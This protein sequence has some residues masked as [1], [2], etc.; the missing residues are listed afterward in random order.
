MKFVFGNISHWARKNLELWME[1]LLI[2]R[3]VEE[4]GE[5]GLIM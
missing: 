5:R 2:W 4:R 1:K 3:G